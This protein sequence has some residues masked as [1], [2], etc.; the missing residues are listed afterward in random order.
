M[1][2]LDKSDGN[3]HQ[4]KNNINHFTSFYESDYKEGTKNRMKPE[5]PKIVLSE[6]EKGK[7]N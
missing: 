5:N 4:I 3:I 2:Q 1:E 6:K 7:K